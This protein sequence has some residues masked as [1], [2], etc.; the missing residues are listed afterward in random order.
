MLDFWYSNRCSREIKLI[1][2]IT[3]CVVI[4]LCSS[5]AQ[6]A[7]PYV[8]ISIAIGLFIHLV[9]T[10]VY[11]SKK[12]W[13][14]VNQFKG[15]FLVTLITYQTYLIFHLEQANLPFLMTQSLG[16]VCIG[17]FICSIYSNRAERHSS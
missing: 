6:L 3:T 2:S 11:Q 9:R 17:I 13:I 16:F 5:K 1:V 12:A 7:T 4:Y 14:N 15:L 10:Y 8:I